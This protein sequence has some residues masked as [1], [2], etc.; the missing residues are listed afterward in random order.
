[1]KQILHFIVRF[2][3]FFWL[4]TF[5]IAFSL[6]SIRWL[7]STK[8]ELISADLRLWEIYM[9]S[10]LSIYSV[11][12]LVG[13]R[14]KERY[15]S[16][17]TYVQDN[18]VKNG[19]VIHLFAMCF[20]S[21]MLLS[22]SEKY[23]SGTYGDLLTIKSLDEISDY[24]KERFFK[25]DSIAYN[26]YYGV[27]FEKNKRSLPSR[28]PKVT[29]NHYIVNPLH[30]SRI[31]YYKPP[32]MYWMALHSRKQISISVLRSYFISSTP[33]DDIKRQRNQVYDIIDT[34]DI[35]Q[36]QFFYKRPASSLLDDYK[37]AIASRYGEKVAKTA[38]VLEPKT[39]S[40]EEKANHLLSPFRIFI[41]ALPILIFLLLT[42][43]FA[44][45]KK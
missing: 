32:L 41:V 6:L 31:E 44:Q 21:L 27:F 43:Y 23:F 9:P 12:F 29:T 30:D 1:M 11:V 39:Y 24:P 2:V 42:T 33:E 19:Y 28:N 14:F 35:S 4:V 37:E 20:V 25:I 38:I 26:P 3:L 34:Y 45:L 16:L 15:N 40:F 7:T 8:C 36:V 17:Y 13:P 22:Y 5:I 18:W 10:I